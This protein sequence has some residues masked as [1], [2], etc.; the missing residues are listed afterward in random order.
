MI[1]R[2]SVFTVLVM[3]GLLVFSAMAIAAPKKYNEA[4]MLAEK[5]AAGLLPPVEERL[6][7][8][9]MVIK[10][11]HGV[12]QYGG[13]WVRFESSPTWGALRMIMYGHSPIRWVDDALG[14]EGNWVESW[15]SNEDAT[16]DSTSVRARG[17]TVFR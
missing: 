16:S 9:P 17:L 4:P 13:T 1:R 3:I 2:S 11:L 14:I 8:N 10:P 6:P 15:E 7:E 5:V 12:G